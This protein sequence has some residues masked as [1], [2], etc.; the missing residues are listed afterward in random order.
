MEAF[1]VTVPYVAFRVDA[2]V[3]I[4]IGHVARCL[5][6]ADALAAR[7]ARCRFVC[8]EHAGYPLERIRSRGHDVVGI[9]SNDGAACERGAD[10]PAHAS[11][12]GAPW[13]VDARR[14][15]AALGGEH[16]DWL[17]VDHYGIDARWERRL[18]PAASRLMVIDDLVDRAHD[19]DL[20]LDQ[21]L[22]AARADRAGRLPRGSAYLA[23]PGLALLRPEF[24]AAR[25][26]SLARRRDATRLR[27]L[28]I[29]MGGIDTGDATGVAL[30]ALER[31]GLPAGCRVT[32]A[33]GPDAPWI[34]RVEARARASALPVE[35]RVDP[36]DVAAL[37]AASDLCI[38]A[39]GGTAWERCCVGLP[40]VVVTLAD[41]QHAVTA[42]LGRAGA[43]WPA[44]LESLD[45][46][47]A[48]VLAPTGL[49]DRLAR[50]SESAA[51]ITDGRGAEA[52]ADALLLP[53]ASGTR[54]PSP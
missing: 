28:L 27:R 18:R 25:G 2:G 6:L 7:G 29:S 41:N 17:I 52:V 47:L 53:F 42:A 37:M 38:G 50:A 33:M 51:T 8:R 4:G 5:T 21:T 44:T 24:A 26:A 49:E 13:C 54:F 36:P 10:D 14:T 22:G 35:V 32:I 48:R 45:A 16:H 1:R 46:D 12:L 31:V 40:A 34:A 19:C 20:L 39:A 23:G 9:A 3:D 11:W 43:A 30:A 15:L